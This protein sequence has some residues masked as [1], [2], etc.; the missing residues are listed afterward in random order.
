[1]ENIIQI[2]GC[3]ETLDNW[4]GNWYYDEKETYDLLNSP[5]E[6]NDDQAFHG[7]D[8]RVYFIDDLIGKKVKCGPIIFTIQEEQ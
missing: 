2:T 1:M 8:H 5:D 4:G 7:V 3:T 6:W